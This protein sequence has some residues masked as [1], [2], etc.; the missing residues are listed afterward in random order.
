MYFMH[1]FDD[2]VGKAIAATSSCLFSAKSGRKTYRTIFHVTQDH[3]ILLFCVS[4]CDADSVPRT[5][6]VF[7]SKREILLCAMEPSFQRVLHDLGFGTK[8]IHDCLDSLTRPAS[9]RATF[10]VA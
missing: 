8:E 5:E 4:T 9:A 10:S 6:N 2:L 7:A 1:T 3:G